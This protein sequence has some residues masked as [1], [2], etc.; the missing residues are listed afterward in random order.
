MINNLLLF[1]STIQQII[2]LIDVKFNNSSSSS[3]FKSAKAI[4]LLIYKLL[5]LFQ[6]YNIHIYWSINIFLL[7]WTLLKYKAILYYLLIYV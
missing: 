1:K 2:L 4:F 6:K 7:L 3:L 5:L